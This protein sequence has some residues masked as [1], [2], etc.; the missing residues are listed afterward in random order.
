MNIKTLAQI[1]KAAACICT[2]LFLLDHNAQ[3]ATVSIL[4][5]I[6]ATLEETEEWFNQFYINVLDILKEV[7][8]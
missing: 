4:T 2:I 6:L 7:S 5:V 1:I 8:E 3:M